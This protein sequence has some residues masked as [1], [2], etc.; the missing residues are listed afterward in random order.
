MRLSTLG[1]DV[2][3]Y[4]D[5]RACNDIERLIS[6][7][8]LQSFPAAPYARVDDIIV[9]ALFASKR[10]PNGYR[11]LRPATAMGNVGCAA[12]IVTDGQA[13]GI[14]HIWNKRIS[15]ERDFDTHAVDTMVKEIVE[16]AAELFVPGD[17]PILKQ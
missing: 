13:M 1:D 9:Y 16:I 2:P 10:H 17:L 8:D 12:R 3:M 4:P 5:G 11:S 15:R 6:R 7:L 14:C